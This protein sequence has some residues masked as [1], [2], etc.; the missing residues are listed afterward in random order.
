MAHILEFWHKDTIRACLI[1][2]Y[3]RITV[4]YVYIILGII[5]F[6][7]VSEKRNFRTMDYLLDTN[8]F[9]SEMENSLEHLSRYVQYSNTDDQKK[10]G[11]SIE[12]MNGLL[13]KLGSSVVNDDFSRD[14]TDITY[15]IDTY[16]QVAEQIFVT[17]DVVERSQLFHECQNIYS[18]VDKNYK[19]LHMNLSKEVSV[20]KS[21]QQSSENKR[22]VLLV[23]LIGVTVL[24]IIR[25][26]YDRAK[27][28]TD[29]I[30]EL[31]GLEKKIIEGAVWELHKMEVRS[32]MSEEMEIL[33]KSFNVMM[34][35][36]HERM[37]MLQEKAENEIK[38]KTSQLFALQTQ[39]NPHFLFNTLNMISQTVFLD[40]KE[41]TM[42]LLQST[43]RLLRYCLDSV[44]KSVSLEK[45]IEMLGTY[46]EL[47]EQRFGD[48]IE[49]IF[50]LDESFHKVQVPCLILQPLIE[51]CMIHGVGT[52]IRDG[53][54]VITTRYD[55]ERQKGIISVEDNGE[56]ISPE[57]VDRLNRQIE[58]DDFSEK[59]IGLQNIA[60]KLRLFFKDESKVYVTSNQGE[61]TRVNI[62]IP[63]GEEFLETY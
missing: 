17:S 13:E 3:I 39:M 43:A 55:K 7:H 8:S 50:D 5:V 25:N 33:V 11:E 30:L 16:V 20:M 29:P 2:S 52:F 35:T 53:K 60:W 31:A 19:N 42:K 41:L 22:L 14:I 4:F 37:Q 40:N 36:I 61:N 32:D 6:F 62:E 9:Y 59:R 49:F 38:L 56:G 54:I 28:I 57:E 18:Y 44:R 12:V 46:I 21:Q 63:V 47:Q 23:F 24:V 58:Q 34:D 51:N 45:E 15:Q 10:A 26:A 1:R 27:G 48:R